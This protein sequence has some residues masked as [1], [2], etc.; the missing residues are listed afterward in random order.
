MRRITQLIALVLCMMLLLNGC[1]PTQY[2]LYHSA[3]QIESISIVSTDSHTLTPKSLD[4]LGS[5]V[6]KTLEH[7]EIG[8]FI[9]AF[10]T[11]DAWYIWNDAAYSVEG[12]GVLVTYT[13]GATQVI[14][15]CFG[16]YFDGDKMENVFYGLDPDAFSS[17]INSYLSE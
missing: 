5:T 13:N 12:Q 6:V 14:G 7:R 9:S 16:F 4:D 10:Q 8:S 15:V 11:M 1:K 3:E 2:P 17:L